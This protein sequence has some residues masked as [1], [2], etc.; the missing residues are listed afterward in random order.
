MPPNPTCECGVCNKCKQRIRSKRWYWR[1]RDQV[2]EVVRD[3][4][5]ENLESVRLYDRERG[6][7]PGD[8]SKRRARRQ[9]DI[10]LRNGTLE[11]CPCEVCGDPKVQAHHEDYSLPLAVRWLCHKHHGQT[12]RKAAPF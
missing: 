7:R 8:A 1:N 11:R 6:Y 12:H 2:C 9:V 3:R 10:A 5:Q 4:R